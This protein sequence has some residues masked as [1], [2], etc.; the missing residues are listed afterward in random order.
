M[1]RMIHHFKYTGTKREFTL[2]SGKYLCI[3]KGPKGGEANGIQNKG[4]CSYGILNLSSPLTL[5]A[6]V[7]GEGS[8][9]SYDYDNNTWVRSPGGYNGGGEGGLSSKPEDPDP[10][11]YKSGAG[12]GGGTDIRLT[13][14]DT[15]R[16]FVDHK[17]PDDL[18]QVEYIRS[19]NSQSID[20]NIICNSMYGFEIKFIPHDSISSNEYCI[21]GTG[22]STRFGDNDF[23]LT[24]YKGGSSI[25]N[26][27]S[28][29]YGSGNTLTPTHVYDAHMVPNTLMEISYIDNKYTVNGTEYLIE[30]KDF[31]CTRSFGI[32]GAVRGGGTPS[33]RGAFTLYHFKLYDENKQ[34]VR[35]MIPFK[36]TGTNIDIS[37]VTL[38]QGTITNGN[39]A[40]S[41]G[42]VR[43]KEF[44]PVPEN[45][46]Y[47]TV[48]VTGST[49]VRWLYVGYRE[50][51][52]Y[53][54]ANGWNQSGTSI[55][56]HTNVK[57]FRI[58]FQKA[59]AS[60]MTPEDIISYDC[61]LKRASD[62][63]GLY[64]LVEEKAYFKKSGLDFTFGEVV[65]KTIYPCPMEINI[66][67][68]S[69]IMVAGGG[70]GATL[71]TDDNF[72]NFSG[73]GG[74]VNGG[75]PRVYG[76][77]GSG[78]AP[79][80]LDY[81]TQSTGY[82]FGIGQSALDKQHNSTST[83]GSNGV[84]GGGGGWFGGYT[85]QMKTAG[86]TNSEGGGGGGSGYILT[87]NSYRPENYL[88]GFPVRDDLVFTDTLLTSGLS[89]ESCVIICEE[90]TTYMTGDKIICDCIGETTTFPLYAGQYRI[91]CS[92]GCG[93]QPCRI[94]R[95]SKG[96]Y[97][98]G[99]LNNPSST[100]AYASVGG[101][102]TYAGNDI[103]SDYAQTTHPTLCFN[104]GGNPDSL[105]TFRNGG[106]AGGGATDLRIGTNS[107]YARV[108]V[109]GGGGGSGSAPGV[110][111]YGYGL[112]GNG[113]GNEGGIYSSFIPGDELDGINYGPGK[114][115]KAGD[116]EIVDISGRF[117]YGGNGTGS[118][119][120]YAGAGGGGWFGGSGT[121]LTSGTGKGGSGGSGYVL[122]ADSYKPEGYL[123]DSSYYM[124]D[125]VNIIGGCER[126][127]SVPIT[128]MVIDVLLA[129]TMPLLCHDS[130]GYKYYDDENETW[131]FLKSDPPTKSDFEDYGAISFS[132]DTGLNTTYDIYVL[133]EID[134]TNTMILGVLPPQQSIKF[135]YHTIHMMTSYSVDSDVDTNV[136]DLRIDAERTG[137]AE[138]A[139]IHFTFRYNI[140]DVPDKLTRVYSITGLTHGTTWEYHE[141]TIPV[142]TLDHID[143]L[144]VGS[145][146]RMPSRYKNYIGSFINGNV[147]IS[148]INSAVV[149]EHNRCVYSA[150]LCN[151]EILRI[152]K[153]TL[154]TNHS[155][156]IKDIH[157]STFNYAKI[158]DIKVDD[159]YIYL[160]NAANNADTNRTIWRTPNSSDMTILSF[161]L[162]A[163][164]IYDINA[165]G[166]MEWYN[167][168]TIAFLVRA[169]LIFFNTDDSTFRYMMAPSG[170]QNDAR[171]DMIV[172][173]KYILSLYD[174]NSKTAYVIDPET[175]TWKDLKNDFG[176]S[177]VGEY[178]SC[179]CY[180][181]GIFYV[182]QRN[183]LHYLVERTMTIDFTIPTPFTTID[184]KQV[185]YSNGIL[186]IT[187]QN[188]PTLFMYNIAEMKFYNT[189][190]PFK[191]DNYS[192][193]GWIR[194]CGFKGY[195]FV[196]QIKLYT[197]NFSAYAKYNLGYKYDQFLIITNRENAEDPDNE[198]EY[199]E[200]FVSF[201][202]DNMNI[203]D[204][205]IEYP[206]ETVDTIN[207]I[208]RCSINKSQYNKIL[209]SGFTWVEP[210]EEEGV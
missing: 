91:K 58:A 15:Q 128:G 142:K 77:G 36:N 108:I 41:T 74:G 125:T 11:K 27:G 144:P 76:S 106:E 43:T 121:Y 71:I 149:C 1:W 51:K 203:H 65:P 154:V 204:G 123:L 50:D 166:K 5:Y 193:D 95:V 57:Y 10:D 33:N 92:G 99:I 117:G 13:D 141:P 32:F 112:G 158:G 86:Y 179:G 124:T 177:F 147:A 35:Y 7:G 80:N 55:T 54:T 145:A 2:N 21:F 84:G 167:S 164:S 194:M 170:S 139:Y 180:H 38:E 114:Q 9:A 46:P 102:G 44:I 208:K 190:I 22:E 137:V 105:A 200:R 205:D 79:H 83:T 135:R 184:P 175:G 138:D 127:Y 3:C 199:D 173:D 85:P 104:G 183:R 110:Y 52:T 61:K 96:G 134:L 206:L 37:D 197:I 30:R 161:N 162:P 53:Y 210:E 70:G 174:G 129:S 130:E 169:G 119:A 29:M 157:I 100:I 98:E 18:E 12:G 48:N 152:A 122:T 93:G 49:T 202:E 176:Q 120:G 64:D 185:V 115:N 23:I 72:S 42:N 118:S 111:S 47:F 182:V 148:E 101:S 6:T 88:A 178:P 165:A 59:N 133:D 17:L 209:R 168:N 181:D 62:A 192:A 207:N 146:T 155:T 19:S 68:L 136:V 131:T 140:H 75:Y 109:A 82:E 20:L 24:T 89:D 66:G 4:G 14:A 189:G 56:L 132:T 8:K 198:Y 28:F 107:L 150:T 153:L 113:G 143:L 151:N 87:D 171:R 116:G 31:K 97:T 201:E 26:E 126:L 188:T 34:L 187:V 94:E 81:A 172:G 16:V 73:F 90:A 25:Q 196:P 67:L 39:D 191:M 40:P 160:S 186:Y 78:D 156:I 195:C 159:N 69:R 163:S 63:A 60:A 103:G 45:Q